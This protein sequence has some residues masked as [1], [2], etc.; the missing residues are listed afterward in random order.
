MTHLETASLIFD[1]TVASSFIKCGLFPVF[2]NCSITP[3]TISSLIPSVS[4]FLS[5]NDRGEGGGVFSYAG[6]PLLLGRSAKET[7]FADEFDRGLDSDT[8]DGGF[9]VCDC[10]RFFVGG[11]CGGDSLTGEAFVIEGRCA[12]EEL[13][14]CI[15]RD[16]SDRDFLRVL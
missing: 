9:E 10:F 5:V 15:P 3:T 12:R 8:G 2:S 16:G 11:C 7:T 13:G 1:R 4:I 6:L 14:S